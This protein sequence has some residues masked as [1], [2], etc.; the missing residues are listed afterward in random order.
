VQLDLRVN[1]RI[2]HP[3]HAALEREEET[4]TSPQGACLKAAIVVRRS[5][6]VILCCTSLHTPI[7]VQRG[8]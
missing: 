6:S 4:E 2:L 8:I 7:I 3:A 1:R 5:T